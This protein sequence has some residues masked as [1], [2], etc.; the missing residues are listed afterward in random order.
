[1]EVK[2]DPPDREKPS[3]VVLYLPKS[4]PLIG[5]VDGINV[6]TRADQKQR[7]DFDHVLKLY[8]KKAIQIDHT[9]YWKDQE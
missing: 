8:Q 9:L 3:R 5:S 1:V 6:V 7:W 2:F 4:R